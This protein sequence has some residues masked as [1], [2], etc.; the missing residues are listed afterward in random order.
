NSK[1]L[2]LPADAVKEKDCRVFSRN[3]RSKSDD[4]KWAHNGIVATIIN[5]EVIPVVQNRIMDV[6]FNDLF[7]F[8]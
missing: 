1:E 4:V 6:G 7:S 8:L 5:G 2:D 3:Y